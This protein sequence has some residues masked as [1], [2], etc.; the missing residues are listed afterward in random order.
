M[1]QR[2]LT[3]S[4]FSLSLSHTHMH[5]IIEYLLKASDYSKCVISIN[6]CKSLMS[7]KR[8][9]LLLCFYCLCLKVTQSQQ[10]YFLSI[11]AVS[12]NDLLLPFLNKTGIFPITQ[13]RNFKQTNLIL[14]S[15]SSLCKQ[16]LTGMFYD[17][18]VICILIANKLSKILIESFKSALFPGYQLSSTK[19]CKMSVCWTIN[20]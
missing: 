3:L 15:I 6:L 18:I 10:I 14:L 1:S 20:R 7:P 17:E 5:T 2:S 13:S 4:S 12:R 16:M 8:H 9:V 19:T 11:Q